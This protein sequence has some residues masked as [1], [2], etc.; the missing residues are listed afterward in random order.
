[1]P[2]SKHYQP[3]QTE[4]IRPHVTEAIYIGL[5][6][7]RRSGRGLPQSRTAHPLP[8]I[9][10]RGRESGQVFGNP[11]A[12]RAGEGLAAAATTIR[13]YKSEHNLPSGNE[14]NRVQLAAES[15]EEREIQP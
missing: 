14:L 3:N 11:Q 1:M 10:L 8:F 15:K 7:G 4:P 9:A 2:L 6:D 12:E 5:P 13:R